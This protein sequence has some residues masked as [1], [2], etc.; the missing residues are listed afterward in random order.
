MALGTSRLAL[1]RNRLLSRFLFREWASWSCA[2]LASEKFSFSQ[3]CRCD[4]ISW[5][6]ESKGAR[7]GDLCLHGTAARSDFYRR[8]PIRAL[9]QPFQVVHKNLF[10]PSAVKLERCNWDLPKGTLAEVA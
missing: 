2:G 10:S 4:S 1:H 8:Q 7:D 3:G 5:P 6:S 9:E